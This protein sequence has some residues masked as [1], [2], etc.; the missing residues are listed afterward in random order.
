MLCGGRF[1]QAENEQL[2][3]GGVPGQKPRGSDNV[4]VQ[5]YERWRQNGSTTSYLNLRF[6]RLC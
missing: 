6:L 4:V 3:G 1:G 2:R 5:L